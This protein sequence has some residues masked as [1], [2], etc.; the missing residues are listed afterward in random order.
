M[1]FKFLL[2]AF[3]DPYGNVCKLEKLGIHVGAQAHNGKWVL[4]I[5]LV[6]LLEVLGPVASIGNRNS[7]SV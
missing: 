2:G 1:L 4:V 3:S 6:Y 7:F 5:F